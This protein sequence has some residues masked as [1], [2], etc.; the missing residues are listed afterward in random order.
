MKKVKVF[1]PILL[2]L[3]WISVE[4][5]TYKVSR[6]MT[7]ADLDLKITERARK[8]IQIDVDLIS[9]GRGFQTK[10][11]RASIYFPIIEKILKEENVPDEFK[12]LAIQESALLSDVVSSSNAVGYWQFKKPAAEEVGLRVDKHVD[13]RMNIISATRGAAK[14]LRK[15]YEAFDNWIYALL[16]YNTGRGGAQKEIKKRYIGARKMEIDRKMHWYVKRFLAHKVAFGKELQNQ[17]K[18]EV[19]LASYSRGANKTL[20]EIARETSTDYDEVSFYNKWLQKGKVPGDR[21]YH[22][23]IPLQTGNKKQYAALQKGDEILKD[24]ELANQFPVIT[25]KLYDADRPFIVKVNG[26]PGI[27]AEN[28]D[29]QSSMIAKAGI[30]ERKFLKYND[31]QKDSDIVSGQVYYVKNKKNKARLHYHTVQ[32]DE[33]LWKISQKF[34]IKLRKLKRKNRIR[35]DIKTVKA[36]R[37]LW[38]RKK[39]SKGTP[40]EYREKY[41]EELREK[42]EAIP[43]EVNELQKP[44]KPIVKNKASTDEYKKN[45]E[46]EGEKIV[47]TDLNNKP[48]NTTKNEKIIE[49]GENDVKTHLVKK[50]ETLYGIA[51]KYD[52]T[53]EEILALNELGID[54]GVQINQKLKVPTGKAQ[55]GLSTDKDGKIIYEVKPGDTLYKIANQYQ[56]TVEDLVKWNQKTGFDVQVGERVTVFLSD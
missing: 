15:N 44:E 21:I 37:V 18:P 33:S 40:I 27:I 36:G 38:L 42:E 52:T 51:K 16:A 53:V 13:E 55:A 46:S 43:A 48:K 14:Y 20:K 6:D 47:R 4:G 26:I 11:E 29:D 12:Y 28:E 3:I 9:S 39:R 19:T 50:G 32:P 54:E 8:Q 25:G 5:Q 7:F 45:R 49:N 41:I 23:V 10:L 17:A 2:L 34:G 30:S 1:L 22:V 56:V 31:L 35:K 24:D